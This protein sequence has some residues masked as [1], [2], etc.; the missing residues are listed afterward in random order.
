IERNRGHLVTISSAA[1]LIGVTGLADYSASKFAVF[2]F[3]EAL[4]TELR[5]L[6]SAVKTT[7]ICPFFIDTGMFDGVRSR[8]PLLLPIMKSEKAAARMVG[9]ILRNRKRLIMPPFAY[10][11]YVL[12]LFPVAVFDAMADFFGVNNSMDQFKG[13]KP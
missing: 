1:G 11:V 7:V 2:G 8:F 9:A 4:R 10:S 12:R 3:H 5:R 6:K 13:R